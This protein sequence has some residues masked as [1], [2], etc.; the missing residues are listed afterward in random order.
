MNTFFKFNKILWGL[1]VMPILFLGS[2]KEDNP[3]SL[4]VDHIAVTVKVDRFDK[5]FYEIPDQDLGALKKEYPYLF[6]QQF[7]DAFWLQKKNDT[8]FQE[9]YEEVQL[10]YADLGQLTAEL[11]Q[12]FKHLK[13]YYPD[14]NPQKVITLISEVDVS[15]KAIY[16]DTLSIISLDTY[17][18]AEHRFYKGFPEYLRMAFNKNQILPDLAENFLINQLKPERDR[19]FLSQMIYQGK[20]LYAKEL[21]LPN[22]EEGALMTYTQEQ[23]DWCYANESEMWKYF[24]ENKLLFDTDPK[25][26]I[27]FLQP[28]PFSKFYLEIDTASPG[29]TG[30]WLGWQIVRSYMK[31]NNVTLQQLFEKEAKQLFEESKYKPKK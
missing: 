24:I 1:W 21:L 27:R 18:G 17:L 5:K 20:L 3:K 7:D 11:E 10:Q 6:P 16:A 15:S 30:S 13:Y 29:R 19:S 2:C 12:F 9:L 14:E 25:L 22:V 8:L 28:S 31:N 23:I 4:Q 26:Q